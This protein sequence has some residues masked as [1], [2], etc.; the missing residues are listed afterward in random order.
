MSF[1]N[2]LMAIGMLKMEN[3]D[4]PLNKGSRT[5]W[6]APQSCTLRLMSCPVLPNRRYVDLFSLFNYSTLL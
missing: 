4:G 5:T 6:C 3:L 1:H 2:G